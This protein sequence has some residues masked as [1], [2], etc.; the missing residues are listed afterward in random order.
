M[1]AIIHSKRSAFTLVELL[2]VIAIIGILAALLLPALAAAQ[3]KGRRTVCLNNQ[4]QVNVALQLYAGANGDRLPAAPGTQ[5]IVNQYISSNS[6]LIFYK[7]LVRSYA[8]IP[9]AAPQPDKVFA[10]PADAFYY[11][12]PSPGY[13]AGAL[14]ALPDTD[15]S[16]FGFNG[17]GGTDDNPPTLPDQAT[18]PGLFGWKISA[19]NNPV[20]TIML[21]DLCGFLPYSW[22]QPQRLPP[23]QVGMNNAWNVVS[24][25]DGHTSY[26]KL[27]WDSE[28][29]LFTFCYDPPA[30]YDYKWSGN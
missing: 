29:N 8:G 3:R 23:D 17:L 18:F 9:D 7:R 27:Y 19:I 5:D 2:V 6:F 10:C 11:R 13:V 26:I 16:S 1:T 21:T 28:Y 14:A 15:Y 12:W 24:F 4:R 20:K 30:G 25:V 22:H